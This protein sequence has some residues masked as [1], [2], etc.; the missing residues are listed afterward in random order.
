MLSGEYAVIRGSPALVA[1][2]PP[3]YFQI[4]LEWKRREMGANHPY[5]KFQIESSF[6][7]EVPLWWREDSLDSTL[8]DPFLVFL[9]AEIMRL[10]PIKLYP[11]DW[12][13]KVTK[14][15]SPS[16]GFGSSS[17]MAVGMF[18]L[19]EL[20]FQERIPEF[21]GIEMESRARTAVVKA[22]G[23]KGSGYDVASQWWAMKNQHIIQSETT[24]LSLVSEAG[25]FQIQR[26]ELSEEILSR[27]GGFVPT[28]LYSPTCTH[29]K[30]ERSDKFYETASVLAFQLHQFFIQINKRW[31]PQ[32]DHELRG[33]VNSY[34]NWA[35]LHGLT[36]PL[37]GLE[38]YGEL[39]S[40]RCAFKTMGSGYGDCL[41]V[42]DSL[43]VK[44]YQGVLLVDKK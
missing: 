33:M 32:N 29:L 25:G 6:L 39:K 34:L 35:E 7:G 38:R 44:T 8:K 5:P 22:Q 3:Y 16:F 24:I 11:F 10:I 43:R 13:F 40:S 12:C 41:W 30:K 27:L 36:D 26:L 15:F 19:V 23:G 21:K 1:I 9:F 14:S 4:E 17:A 42:L 31:S 2:L 18:G 20:L 37:L 28:N